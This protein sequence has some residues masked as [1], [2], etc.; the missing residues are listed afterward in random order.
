MRTRKLCLLAGPWFGLVLAFAASSP[1]AGAQATAP[2]EWT[3]MGGSSTV[4]CGT[5]GCGQAGA[6]GTL[7]A[8]AAGNIPGSRFYATS[9]T[10]GSGSLW[11]FG[12]FGF[13]ANGTAGSLNDLWEL[14]PS[15]NEW[16][17]KS[18][19]N[20][21]NQSGVYGAL[22][23]SATGNFP[24]G[25]EGASSWTDANGNL[26]LFGGG[27][28]DASGNGG[29]LNDLWEFIPTKSEWVWMSGSSTMSA[30][31]NLTGYS[32]V[33][34]G[35]SVPGTLGT[36]APGNA[37]GGREWAT[38]WIDKNGSLWLFGG[39]GFDPSGNFCILDDLW[40]F[41]PTTNEWE[42]ISGGSTTAGCQ[43]NSGGGV[44]IIDS[45]GESQ[46]SRQFSDHPH[47]LNSAGTTGSGTTPVGR[48][49]ASGWTDDGG[50]LWL[51]GGWGVSGFANDLWEFDT[52]TLEWKLIGGSNALSE[53]G[54]YGALGS[55]A[56]GNMPGAREYASSWTG[57]DGNFWLSGG[58]GM[59]A[60][61]NVGDLNDL[62]EFNP[63]TSEWAWLGGSSTLICG[64]PTNYGV[65]CSQPGEPGSL[66][67][68]AAANVPGGRYG[69]VSWT[70]SE[71]YSWLFGGIHMAADG[72]DALN[73]VWR[74]Q[75]YAN[76]AAPEFSV[77]AGTYTMTQSVTITDATAGA[78]IYYTTDGSMPTPN[79][80][81]YNGPITVSTSETIAAIAMANGYV[82]SP[83]ASATYTIPPDFTFTINPSSISVQ[84][85]KSGTTI[86]TVQ[87][88]GGFNSNVSFACSGLPAGAA[89]S[90]T[91]ETVPTPAGISY[92]TLTVSTSASTA[93]VER[94]RRL[95]VPG[96]ALAVAFC[97]L[98]WKRR[99]R[100]Q[101]F[102]LL[103]VSLAVMTFL[104]GCGA[105]PP[106]QPVTSTV[107]V[108]A[109][110][111]SLQHS[112]SFSLTV[113]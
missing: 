15:N 64:A 70:D 87:D 82:A 76:T 69:A 90:F 20:A 51:F 30:C 94:G 61:G 67:T 4:S 57:A 91:L 103:P 92:T 35:P 60:V 48:Y 46:K 11:L 110:S 79:S 14:N 39:N 84:A 109:T 28:G 27:G 10:G 31:A 80:T 32:Y 17:W 85:G 37:P 104:A 25:R 33:Y 7:G 58:N 101:M 5:D 86:I 12:G 74:Y 50:H 56:A 93:A 54:V 113:N 73:D 75:P 18:G 105:S 63:S 108:N 62:W 100:L 55:P 81:V 21:A 6:Y 23:T 96:S 43:T 42:W 29:Y 2:N 13:D 3:W 78:T 52:S 19:S 8:P 1:Y 36:P 22:G 41:S 38:S 16:T 44:G 97:L 89:C 9:W 66:G 47:A 72:G 107:T 77:S 99:R 88:E 68:P 95:M 98:G 34:C 83:A 111:G 65:L 102:V 53:P 71:G 40:E 26:W 49:G 45:F 24:G 106:R 59:D 112:T